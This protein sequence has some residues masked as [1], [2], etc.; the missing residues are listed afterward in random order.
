[1]DIAKK[2]EADVWIAGM[3]DIHKYQ[4]QRRRA[5]LAIENNGPSRV[6]LRLSCSTNPE[7]YDQ[8]LTIEVTLPKSWLA[9]RVMVK[10]AQ[11]KAIATRS[12]QTDGRTLLLFEA[13]PRNTLYS[14]EMIP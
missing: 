14:I 13:A 11:D 12:S 5:K 8:P 2:N 9:N 10:N 1:M 7:L 4:T 6:S 3:A